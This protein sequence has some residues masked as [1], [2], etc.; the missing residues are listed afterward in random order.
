MKVGEIVLENIPLT[1]ND[2]KLRN[3]SVWKAPA[4]PALGHT[5]DLTR[6]L[7]IEGK[8]LYLLLL[9]YWN[10]AKIFQVVNSTILL[11]FIFIKCFK[12]VIVNKAYTKEVIRSRKSKDRQHNGQNIPKRS[13]EA[14]SQEGQTTL[15][16]KDTKEVIRSRKSKKDRQKIKDKQTNYKILYRKLKIERTYYY[17]IFEIKLKYFK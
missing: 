4:W 10:K 2:F 9:N 17:W 15:W 14:V 6:P 16:A 7:F 5:I 13:S 3:F 1:T 8:C 11:I 12:Y